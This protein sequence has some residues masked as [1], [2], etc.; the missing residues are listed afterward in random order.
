MNTPPPSR[1]SQISAYIAFADHS[2]GI[3]GGLNISSLR[4]RVKEDMLNNSQA[5]NFQIGGD[6]RLLNN[7]VEWIASLPKFPAMYNATSSAPLSDLLAT[8]DAAKAA[9]IKKVLVAYAN[10]PFGKNYLPSDTE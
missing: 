8:K 10:Q 4:K 6:P 9:Y 1:T 5:E 2:F 7:T 3:G